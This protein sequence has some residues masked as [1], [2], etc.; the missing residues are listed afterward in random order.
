MADVLIFDDDPSVGDLMGELLRGRGVTVSHFL[1]GAGVVQLVQENKPKLVILDIMMPGMDGLTACRTLKSNPAT[2]GAKI[3]ILTAKNYLE[4]QQAAMRYGAD[5]FLHKPFDPGLFASSIGRM[6]GL[7]EAAA[8][9]VAPAPPV[10]VT[11][12]PGCVIMETTGLLMLFD[13]GKGLKGWIEKR[14]HHF[15]LTWPPHATRR[16]P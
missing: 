8:P 13:A 15:P 6:L 11:I 5:L 4:D 1:S 7:S 9:P 12:F 14:N 2:R 10:I 3:A 16:Q